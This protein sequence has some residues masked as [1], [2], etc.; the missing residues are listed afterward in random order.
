LLLWEEYKLDLTWF[1]R[2]RR[3]GQKPPPRSVA[4]DAAP[5]CEVR[6]EVVAFQRFLERVTKT[7]PWE[8]NR[9]WVRHPAGE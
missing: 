9:P 8:P 7:L 5:R 3:V 4:G 6:G 1:G 2:G